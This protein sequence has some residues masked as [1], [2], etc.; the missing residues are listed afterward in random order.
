MEENIPGT[1]KNEHNSGGKAGGTRSPAGWES[2]LED[3]TRESWN[4]RPVFLEWSTFMQEKE[5]WTASQK[6]WVSPGFC[7]HLAA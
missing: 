7:H 3:S 2:V 4:G 6:T 1:G 5:H